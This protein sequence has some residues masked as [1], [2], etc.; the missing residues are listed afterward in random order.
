MSPLT[1][2]VFLIHFIYHWFNYSEQS[3]AGTLASL[4]LLIV[5]QI[6]WVTQ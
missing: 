3:L 5:H 2:K 4:V 1:F 6:S